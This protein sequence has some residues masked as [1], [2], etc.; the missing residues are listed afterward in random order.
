MVR[1]RAST[2]TFGAVLGGTVSGLGWR[3]FQV[4]RFRATII[5]LSVHVLVFG[6]SS[7]IGDTMEQLAIFCGGLVAMLGSVVLGMAREAHGEDSPV[8]G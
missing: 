5:G 1:A 8:I 3:F 7:R 4:G 6:F 2:T